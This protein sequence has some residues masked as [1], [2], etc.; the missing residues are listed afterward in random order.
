[1]KTNLIHKPCSVPLAIIAATITLFF[2]SS[3]TGVAQDINVPGYGEYDI[4]VIDTSYEASQSSLQDQP[5]WGSQTEANVFATALGLQD[6][7][8]GPAFAY[9]S[10]DSNV[11][12]SA[13]FFAGFDDFSEPTSGTFPYVEA[14]IVAVPE[15]AS[16]ILATLSTCFIVG[17]GLWSLYRRK[18]FSTVS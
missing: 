1:M 14:E 10:S 3:F 13:P 7:N 8:P 6:G 12:I 18:K 11:D 5:W 2:T 9:S 17:Q 15:P 4:T 16:W